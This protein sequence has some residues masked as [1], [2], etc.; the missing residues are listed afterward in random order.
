MKHSIQQG[1]RDDPSGG[2]P[3]RRE[4]KLPSSSLGRVERTYDDG[5]NT[6]SNN[7][8]SNAKLEMSKLGI[9]K[10]ILFSLS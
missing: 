6:V 3:Q 10:V 9:P 7:S 4:I 5:W 1:Q 8:R 2:P